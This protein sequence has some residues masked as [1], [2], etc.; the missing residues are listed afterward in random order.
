M[1][2]SQHSDGRTEED[3][4]QVGKQLGGN[5]S[6]LPASCKTKAT[7]DLRHSSALLCLKSDLKLREKKLSIHP[8]PYSLFI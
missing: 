2:K 3:S 5:D 7:L 8:K 1:T 6:S 4:S